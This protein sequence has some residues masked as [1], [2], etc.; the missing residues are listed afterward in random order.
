MLL[1]SLKEALKEK[2]HDSSEAANAAFKNDSKKL[3]SHHASLQTAEQLT[4]K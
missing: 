3:I 2:S 4:L 1:S